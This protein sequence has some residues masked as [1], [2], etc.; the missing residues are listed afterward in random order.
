[1]DLGRLPF[2]GVD[3][4]T[5][6]LSAPGDAV[7]WLAAAGPPP[8][9]RDTAFDADLDELS[10]VG[11]GIL[12]ADDEDPRVLDALQ[13]LLDQR[14]EEAGTLFRKT[15][16][17]GESVEQFSRF[18][19]LAP[20]PADP[21][22]LPFYLLIVGGPDRIP[23]ELQLALDVQRAVGRLAFA[24][25]LAYRQYA[26]SVVSSE[27]ASTRLE[28]RL[29]IFA[30]R[31][32]DD[33]LTSASLDQLARPLGETLA[34]RSGWQIRSTLGADATKTGLRE[35]L[36]PEAG[37]LLFTASHAVRFRA[38]HPR[39]RPEQGAL[40][41]ADWPGPKVWSGAMPADFLWSAADLD[42]A[43]DFSG[44]LP[45]L[46]ACYTAGTPRHDTFV[47]PDRS[48]PVL[49]PEPFVSELASRLLCHPGGG[50]LAVVG[51]LDQTFEGSFSW[52]GA[53][54]RVE[55]FASALLALARGARLGGAL[56]VF[57]RRYLEVSAEVAERYWA[58]VYTG[59]E[60]DEELAALWRAYH[61]ARG[62]SIVGDPA[63]RIARAAGGP[64]IGAGS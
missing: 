63:V 46:F 2:C 9:P 35:L 11:W 61:D 16:Y 26:R 21:V 58:S 24:D 32:D 60:P 14:R 55:T 50:A 29:S 62:F 22:R 51:H 19:R 42:P 20:G 52:P 13:P 5:G 1:M 30:V 33:R 44:L 7:A 17:A 39:Q 45:F 64:R 57:A 38:G 28:S 4:E 3:G 40:V 43:A 18:L 36:H 41:T 59:G 53:G 10:E 37:P 27:S 8:Q 47:R 6:L 54:S 23:Y 31:N 48:P 15:P 49:A 56:E 12:Y 25:P 34:A